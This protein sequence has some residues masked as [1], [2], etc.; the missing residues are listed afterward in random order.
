MVRRRNK[1][2]HEISGYGNKIETDEGKRVSKRVSR[3]RINGREP[4][5]EEEKT[6]F[7][8]LIFELLIKVVVKWIDENHLGAIKD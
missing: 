5:R 3:D 8:C 7:F 4:S 1:P 6:H 2:V